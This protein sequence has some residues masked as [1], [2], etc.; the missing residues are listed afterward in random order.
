MDNR[1]RNTEA[2]WILIIGWCKLSH[3]Q[4]NITKTKELTVDFRRTKPPLTFASIQGED[5]EV[6]HSYKYLEVHL[7]DRL[8]WA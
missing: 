8:E 1:R 6:V 4:L 3:L 7:D 2:W 5:V